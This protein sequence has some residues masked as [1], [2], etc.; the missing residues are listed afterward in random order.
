[1]ADDEILIT[2]EVESLI[3]TPTATLA[4]WR[5]VGKG[6]AWFKAGRRVLYRKSDV[7]RWI[8]E[9]VVTPTSPE[10]AA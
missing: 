10:P 6:P 4:Y 5:S 9:N 8:D 1:M 7:E 3:R 2:E